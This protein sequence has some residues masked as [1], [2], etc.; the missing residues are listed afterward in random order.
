MSKPAPPR[1]RA[2]TVSDA[3]ER[4]MWS[5]RVLGKYWA[6]Q[7]PGTLLLVVILHLLQ[8]HL[9]LS[10]WLL[11]SI[12]GFW[13][14]KDVVLYPV[15]W[16]SYDPGYPA[17]QHSLDG[18]RGI[19]TEPLNPSG[20]VRVRG[21]LWR[22]ELARDARPIKKHEAVQVRAVRGLTLIVAAVDDSP[23]P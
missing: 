21:E 11:W 19:A 18:A 5:A 15:V 20:Y 10:T 23:V 7:I 16:R 12:V 1:D 14:I 4:R 22:A 8:D 6:L 2:S 3:V 17:T 13:V 9:G